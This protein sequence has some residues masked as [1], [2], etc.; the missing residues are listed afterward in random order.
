MTRRIDKNMHKSIIN[1]LK[2]QQDP[3]KRDSYEF[4]DLPIFRRFAVSKALLFPFLV[5][6][7][8]K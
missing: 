6:H 8:K 4:M 3:E 5:T 1:F 2:T 7:R